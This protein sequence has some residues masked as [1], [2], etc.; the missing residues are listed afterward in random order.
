MPK[1]NKIWQP[2]QLHS[3]DLLWVKF[4]NYCVAITVCLFSAES[5]DGGGH[6]VRKDLASTQC[7]S[8]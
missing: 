6:K 2:F 5:Q 7:N 3:Y 8:S 1:Q 4:L